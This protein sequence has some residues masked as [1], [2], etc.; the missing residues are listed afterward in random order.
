LACWGDETKAAARLSG[1]KV[2]RMPKIR[3]DTPNKTSIS[4]NALRVMNDS[5]KVE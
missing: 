4:N 2:I 5:I 1:L 3:T